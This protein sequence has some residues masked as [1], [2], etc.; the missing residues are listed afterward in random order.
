MS[1]AKDTSYANPPFVEKVALFASLTFQLPFFMGWT[2]A[3]SPFHRTNKHKSLK[4]VFGD[5]LF[6]FLTERFNMKQVQW[7]LGDTFGVY[8]TYMK[9]QGLQP[10]VDEIGENGR[11]L[12]LGERRT[13]RVIL[14]CH[15]ASIRQ[16]SRNQFSPSRSGGAFIFPAQFF[17]LPFW[18]HTKN[19]LDL[20]GKGTGIAILQYSLVP[21][22]GFP[23]QLKQAV[24]AVQH[25]LSLGVQPQ[26]IQLTGDSAGGNLV[27]QVLSHILHPVP[28]VPL[29]NITTPLAGA[30]IL[31]PWVDLTSAVGSMVTNADSDC[32]GKEGLTYW[33]RQVRDGVAEESRPYIEA[34]YA[35]DGWFTKLS[36]V[37]G[38]I[39]V[40]GGD[41]ECLR[42]SIVVFA[43]RLTKQH[44]QTK[45][46][47]QKHGVHNDP[48]FDFMWDGKAQ[49]ELRPI[50]L[51][52]FASNF[53]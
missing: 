17:V 49:N 21:T 53:K 15:G 28:N 26:N 36:T 42:D 37:V 43:D 11:I 32:I 51:D 48:Y 22:A 18:K 2:L 47:L 45:F 33:G 9:S 10:V 40:T 41:A 52:F 29:L 13:D 14:Y 30:F 39:L 20:K 5:R 12:W 1:S 24:L 34:Y 31:S 23:T 25:L 3:T 27:L 19:E 8:N 38:P 35:P 4:R 16:L 50:I 6:Y 7:L 44:P 46:V